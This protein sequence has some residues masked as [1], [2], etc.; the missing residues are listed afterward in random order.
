MSYDPLKRDSSWQMVVPG[1]YL[2]PA[3]C[4]HLFPDELLAFLS[5]AHPEAGFDPNSETDYDLVVKVYS[6]MLRKLSPNT[7]TVFVEHERQKH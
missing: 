4:G 6:E 5:V 3:G 2:D 7:E 1:C